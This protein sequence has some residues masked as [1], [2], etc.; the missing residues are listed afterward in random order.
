MDIEILWY[1]QNIILIN[2]PA[3]LL[4]IRDG[5]DPSLPYVTAI[6]QP[7]YGRLFVVHRLDR[8]TSGI[9][10]LAKNLESH[11]FLNDQFQNRQTQKIYHAIIDGVPSWE[12]NNAELPLL[13]DADRRHRT[14]VDFQK[15]KPAST[16]F[17]VMER[18]SANCLVKAS[19]Q[20]GYTHQIRA[21]L[22]ALGYPILGDQLYSKSTP[23]FPT[24][25]SKIIHKQPLIKRM[26]LHAFSLSFIHPTT[27]A[28]FDLKAPY[29]DDFQNT[30]NFLQSNN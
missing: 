19:P 9:L 26:A 5:Y 13:I 8:D 3:G 18:F 1:D 22:L 2:K 11:K 25:N 6:L 21:H 28:I 29:P 27:H 23:S 20:T 24:F 12:K 4:T 15:G 14:R 7:E 17:E 30:L 16:S 10:L